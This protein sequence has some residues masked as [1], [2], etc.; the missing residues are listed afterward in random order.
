MKHFERV[1][2]GFGFFG[3]TDASAASVLVGAEINGFSLS[4][5]SSQSE[6][7]NFSS[8]NLYGNEGK[9]IRLDPTK[10]KVNI[11]SLFQ[12]NDKVRVAEKVLSGMAGVHTKKEIQP[13][14]EIL[15]LQE[16]YL[17]K[18][19]IF[20]RGDRWGVRNKKLCVEI[21]CDDVWQ[22]LWENSSPAMAG[23]IMTTLAR[24]MPPEVFPSIEGG[25]DVKEV[26]TLIKNSLKNIIDSS[27]LP[28]FL[29]SAG[30]LIAILDFYGD[31]PA[32]EVD[33]YVLAAYLSYYLSRD[34]LIPR[35]AFIERL[36]PDEVRLMKLETYINL[37]L[38]RIN[39]KEKYVFS[40]HGLRQSF[41]L[42]KKNDYLKLMKAVINAV[43]E[44]GAPCSILYG[45]LLGAVRDQGFIPFDDDVDLCFYTRLDDEKDLPAEVN[46]V[47][48]H[49]GASGFKVTASPQS[50]V[51]HIGGEIPGVAVDLFPA[52]VCGGR[53][54]V[55]MEKM[56]IRD[57][58]SSILLPLGKISLYGEEFPVPA[59]PEEFLI[60]RYGSTWNVSDQFFEWP[61]PLARRT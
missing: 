9:R 30:C 14:F 16:T 44:S 49:L 15:F 35:F 8:L 42:S 54:F 25:I 46:R 51:M 52:R 27:L 57:I 38:P 21:L 13:K 48:A 12:D 22:P 20:N 17:E 59:R 61:Y 43:G 19:I 41:L 40:R 31:A 4:I 33:L 24:W 23:E 55:Y 6:I 29:D 3:T 37:I 1:F 56:K 2:P 45:S 5:R 7:L 10:C 32:D 11:S 47:T 26:R 53:V 18:I 60:E 39:I 36:C 34:R 50:L 58:D 28:R